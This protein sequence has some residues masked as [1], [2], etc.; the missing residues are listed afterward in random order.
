[1]LSVV[2]AV[3]RLVPVVSLDLCRTG[4]FDIGLRRAL[5]KFI[6][7]VYCCSLVKEDFATD[8]TDDVMLGGDPVTAGDY[9]Y[10]RAD[11]GKCCAWTVYRLS[12]ATYAVPST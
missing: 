10:E 9:I 3:H 7:H 6:R 5:R 8:A 1:V 4:T 12:L 2:S 11:G